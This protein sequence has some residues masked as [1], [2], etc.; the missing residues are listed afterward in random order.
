MIFVWLASCS[1]ALFC[2]V[3]IWFLLPVAQMFSANRAGL[4]SQRKERPDKH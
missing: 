2:V 3:L 1:S 4:A